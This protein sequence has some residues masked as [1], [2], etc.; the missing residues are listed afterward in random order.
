VDKARLTTLIQEPHQL[1][2]DDVTPLKKLKEEYPYFQALTP[3]LVLSDKKFEP[4]AEQK[5]LPS[6][7]I[8]ALDRR[9]LKNLLQKKATGVTETPILPNDYKQVEFTHSNLKVNEDHLP[10]SFFNE[11]F[12]EMES[13]KKS[14]EQYRRIL[15]KLEHQ[16]TSP[17]F[18]NPAKSTSRKSTEKSANEKKVAKAKPKTAI[19]KTRKPALSKPAITKETKP[20]AKKRTKPTKKKVDNLN[21]EISYDFINEI[22]SKEKKEINDQHKKEQI[23]L[24]ND[25]IEKEPI[26][27]KKFIESDVDTKRVIEDLSVSSTNLS[28]DVISET[29][30]KLMVKQ[31]RNQKAIDIYKKLIWKFPQKKTY[32]AEQIENLKREQ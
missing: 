10:D 24:I 3:L 30:A 16:G 23:A 2:I 4:S 11:L 6:A 15:E 31:G 13:L 20:V 18:R 1:T 32:F 25:F 8:Y 12:V 27:T 26:L 5:S 14:K 22:K 28:D 17:A 7:S 29:L 21:S 19:A 9:H